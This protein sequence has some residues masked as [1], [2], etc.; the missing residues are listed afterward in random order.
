[1]AD[2]AAHVA[3]YQLGLSETKISVALIIQL[4]GMASRRD[5]PAPEE[6]SA[7]YLAPDSS[8]RTTCIAVL[9]AGRW[10]TR[11]IAGDL[12]GR[13]PFDALTQTLKSG[14]GPCAFYAAYGT[15]GK[16]VRGWLVA[17]NWDLAMSLDASAGGRQGA[18]FISMANPRDRWFWDAVYAL[19]PSAVA[20]LARRPEGCRA[21]VLAGTSD[22]PTIPSLDIMRVDRRWGRIPR[23]VEGQR[24]LGDVARA[25]GRD[26][27]VTF[28]TS[29]QPVDTALATALKRPV[30]EWTTEWERGFVRP[31]RLGPVAPL[32]AS[33]TAVAIA[34]LV[35]SVV[36][37]AASRRQVR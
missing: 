12:G 21:A 29:A 33:A 34:V 26:H 20:C 22:D 16:T 11:V 31:I 37:A 28:W 1:M 15:P 7:A 14:L 2:S 4:A 19:P 9:S 5:R 35:L 30:G 32:G 3:W 27:F 6:Q 23:L 36:A 8:D 10:W 17:R 13:V 24:F 18:S 25:V